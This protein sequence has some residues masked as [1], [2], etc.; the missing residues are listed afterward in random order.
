MTTTVAG[1]AIQDPTSTEQKVYAAFAYRDGSSFRFATVSGGYGQW[2]GNRMRSQSNKSFVS[3]DA[4][5]AAMADVWTNKHLKSSYDTVLAGPVTFDVPATGEIDP[6]ALVTAARDELPI[7]AASAAV[8][9]HTVAQALSPVPAS[10]S[11]ATAAPAAD[12]TYLPIDPAELDGITLPNGKVMYPRQVAG[13]TDVSMLR[14]LRDTDLFV[15]L[16]GP[17]GGGKSTVPYGA[18][19]NDLVVM[20]GHGDTTVAHFV[21]QHLPTPD[22][23]FEWHDGPLTQAMKE[24]KVFFLDEA[25]RVPSEALAVLMSV[26]DGRRTL[27][28]D[29]LPGSEPVVAA[30]GFWMAISYNEFGQGVRPLDDAIKRRF[31]ISIEVTADFTAAEAAGVDSRAIKVARNLHTQNAQDVTEG[32]LGCWVPQI[33][34]L[35]VVQQVL[36]AGLGLEVALATLVS[37]CTDPGSVEKVQDAIGVT[38]GMDA[39]PLAL[40]GRA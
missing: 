24:G 40:G 13:H 36:D 8:V 9:S 39:R 1:F 33:A 7:L 30:D 22:G 21:G 5:A 23:G 14:R 11:A 19:G 25:S 18:F 10:Q 34:D 31:P 15:R 3:A 29:D 2:A 37:A 20:Q 4:A 32:G 27:H 6:V 12:R 17:A 16:H 38:F 28:L 26:A 35:L